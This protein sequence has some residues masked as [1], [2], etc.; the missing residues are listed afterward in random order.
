VIHWSTGFNIIHGGQPSLDYADDGTDTVD[1]TGV[2]EVL[3]TLNKHAV[4]HRLPTFFAVS[5]QSR[6]WLFSIE[7]LEWNPES[8]HIRLGKGVELLEE[9]LTLK[10]GMEGSDGKGDVLDFAEVDAGLLFN[11]SD[12][13]ALYVTAAVSESD[14]GLWAEEADWLVASAADDVIYGG[15]GLHGIEG[16][17]GADLIDARDVTPGTG[18]SRRATTSRSTGAR[19]TIPSSSA[20]G[21]RCSKAAPAATRSC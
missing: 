18:T 3:I 20:K 13:G 1:Y 2:G 8:D 6:D 7:R 5:E 14:A 4:P 21:A 11:A 12:D 10:L 9:N 15:V 16:S 17:G 19:G